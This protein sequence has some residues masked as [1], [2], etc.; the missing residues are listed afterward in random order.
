MLNK[1]TLIVKKSQIAELVDYVL[2][3]FNIEDDDVLSKIIFDTEY[4]FSKHRADPVSEEKR[5]KW[6]ETIDTL[7]NY[8][9]SLISA[10]IA[11]NLVPPTGTAVHKDLRFILAR[12]ALNH[13][14]TIPFHHIVMSEH[15]YIMYLLRSIETYAPYVYA[16]GEKE[17]EPTVSPD[18]YAA[19][20]AYK[21]L[22]SEYSKY[23]K[24]DKWKIIY[25]LY[26]YQ[27][28][29]GDILKAILEGVI[30]IYYEHLADLQN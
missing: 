9:K 5:Q 12:L 14:H 15:E 4:M 16:L 27:S 30:D 8:L 2:G 18:R 26:I 1:Y 20:I 23:S 11:S 7:D 17:E 28:V 19:T 21:I 6:Q 24:K 3:M 10:K 25:T 13:K 29:F 22:L